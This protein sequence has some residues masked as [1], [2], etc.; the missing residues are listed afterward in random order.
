MAHPLDRRPRRSTDHLEGAQIYKKKAASLFRDAY[1]NQW[2]AEEE[3]R[4]AIL[5]A[6]YEDSLRAKRE[7]GRFFWSMIFAAAGIALAIFSFGGQNVPV[8][9][10]DNTTT[11]EPAD[12]LIK[13]LSLVT[14]GDSRSIATAWSMLS[15]NFIIGNGTAR[16]GYTKFWSE[17]NITANIAPVLCGRSG[18][19]ATIYY[20]TTIRNRQSGRVVPDSAYFYHMIQGAQNE[21]LIF[22]K[23]SVPYPDWPGSQG[24]P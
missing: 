22:A 21:W 12:S 19:H 23:V 3:T 18:N 9:I 14:S 2:S 11:I 16:E 10:S 1:E 8:I 24:C 15:D 6:E 13:Y 7:S 4:K 5:A 20:E 17:N